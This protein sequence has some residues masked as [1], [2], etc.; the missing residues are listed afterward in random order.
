MPRDKLIEPEDD[1]ESTYSADVPPVPF[2]PLGHVQAHAVDGATVTFRCANGL[3]R[4]TALAEDCFRVWATQAPV[5]PELFSYAVAKPDAEWDRPQP[6]ALDDRDQVTVELRDVACRVS[7]MDSGLTF[8][9]AQGHPI[10]TDEF[11]GMAWQ[12]GALW[13]HKRLAPGEAVY[14]LGEHACALNLR[15]RRYVL[16]N[17]DPNSYNRGDEPIYF[18]IPFYVALREDGRAYGLFFDNTYRGYVDVGAEQP[19]RLTFGFEGGELRYY[20]FTGPTVADVLAR[21][22]ELT[23]RMALPPLWALGYHQCRWSYYPEVRVREI[24][25]EFRKRRIPCDA[26]YLDIDYMDG[27]RCFTWD[28]ERFPDPAG[29][30]RDLRADGFRTVTMIDPAIKIDPDYAVYRSGVAQDV[31]LKH[32]DGAL[33]T[34]SVWAGPSHFPDFTSPKVRAWWADLYAELVGMGVAGFWNDMNEPTVFPESGDVDAEGIH[35]LPDDVPHHW[36]GRGA[37][38]LAAHNVYGMLMGRATREGLERLRPD[39]RP[40]VIIRAAYAGAQRYASSWTGDNMSTWDHVRLSISMCLNLGLSG[41]SF[42]GPDIGGFGGVPDGEMVTRW[43]QLGACLPFFR[44]HTMT[45]TP[46]QEPWSYGQPYED[47]NRRYIE[48]R[49]ELLPYIYSAVARCAR[50]GLPIVRPMFMHGARFRNVDDQFMLGDHLLVAPVL[51]AGQQSRTVALPKGLWYDFWTGQRFD[52][53]DGSVE[54]IVPAPLDT[55]PLFVRAGA[56]VPLWPVLQYTDERPVETLR[57]RAFM[58]NGRTALYEDEGD[59]PVRADGWSAFDLRLD[60]DTK[61]LILK[62]ERPAGAPLRYRQ[63]DVEVFG[64]PWEV[65]DVLFDGEPAPFWIADHGLV[66]VTGAPVFETL[67]IQP[68]DMPGRGS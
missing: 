15:G 20:L 23:G 10:C 3:L 54:I 24:A 17:Q 56:T 4:I 22:T 2:V 36:E 5:F 35:T 37:T 41:L 30:I 44:M 65:A 16:W 57:L 12:E 14:G 9:T 42:T 38:H 58:G 60:Q 1:T 28:R 25:A 26:I 53:R 39:R 32:P 51:E 50:D 45:G 68:P 64:L 6:T 62:W 61:T 55:L 67:R 13:L 63:V 47:I 8:E 66:Q 29:M 7:K 46:D 52:G 31:F 59:G 27:F 48:F 18:G 11:A 33:Y 49:Y 34:G 43:I 40:F 21:Y 19:D